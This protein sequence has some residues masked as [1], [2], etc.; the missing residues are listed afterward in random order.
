MWDLKAGLVEKQQ[1]VELRGPAIIFP[2]LDEFAWIPRGAGDTA[3]ESTDL[4][5]FT[6]L[7]GANGTLRLS[8][9]DELP[10]SLWWTV[11]TG[12]VKGTIQSHDEREL[13]IG[14]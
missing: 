3:G 10:E 13:V 14:A 7:E 8:K 11:G 5:A 2:K 9:P 4:G 1:G 6:G 12:G